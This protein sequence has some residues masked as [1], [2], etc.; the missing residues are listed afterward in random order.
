MYFYW[1]WFGVVSDKITLENQ[2]KTFKTK[3][4]YQH[5]STKVQCQDCHDFSNKSQS[6]INDILYQLNPDQNPSFHQNCTQCHKELNPQSQSPHTIEIM[7]ENIDCSHCHFE[8]IGKQNKPIFS[9]ETDCTQCHKNQTNDYSEIHSN[10][11]FT[12][13]KNI[14]WKF[15][16]ANHQSLHFAKS[17]HAFDCNTCHITGENGQM[18]NIDFEQSCTSCHQ[19]VNQIKQNPLTLIQIP[20]LDYDVLIDEN[21]NI[22]EWPMDAGIDLETIMNESLLPLFSHDGLTSYELLMEEEVELIDLID[23]ADFADELESYFW[24]LKKVLLE[25]TNPLVL[26]SQFGISNKENIQFV[27]KTILDWFPNLQD[28]LDSFSAGDPPETTVY[29][30][31]STMDESVN[32]LH[33]SAFDFNITYQTTRHKDSVLSNIFVTQLPKLKTTLIA[34]NPGNCLKCHSIID[35]KID[36]SLSRKSQS[37]HPLLKP[38]SHLSHSNESKCNDCHLESDDGFK[39]ITLQSCETCHSNTE[40]KNLCTGCHSYHPILMEIQ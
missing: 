10:I 7:G 36:W 24:E 18:G 3:I 8:H 31:Y 5:G 34:E 20:G 22:G 21:I 9:Q 19:H 2:S 40:Q 16:H 14:K 39:P 28:E 30:D 33:K 37:A 11:E 32:Q 27:Q 23:G 6:I 25:L 13:Q 29:E 38:F 35:N 26:K 1:L 17:N 12:S 15:N 4:C